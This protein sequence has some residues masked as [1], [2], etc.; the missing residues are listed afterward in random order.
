MGVGFAGTV[1]CC[2]RL[3]LEAETKPTV[4][5]QVRDSRLDLVRPTK[6]AVDGRVKKG[7]SVRGFLDDP[8]AEQILRTKINRS[9]C[10]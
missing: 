10:I 4:R 6:K 1:K 2:Q 7:A 3:R 9:E 5:E 8:K